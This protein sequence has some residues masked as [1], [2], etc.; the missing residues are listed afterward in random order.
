MNAIEKKSQTLTRQDSL[1]LKG[2]AI[3]FLI[4][5]HCFVNEEIFS[6]YDVDF[7]PLGQY[8][9][10]RVNS[11]FKTC[12]C[13]FTFISGY[14]LLKSYDPEKPHS[15][16][17]T[18]KWTVRRC[19]KTL[20]GLWAAWV[21]LMI[22][23][24]IINGYP[25][26]VYFGEGILKGIFYMAVEAAGGAELLGTPSMTSVWWYI[27]AAVIYII[28]LP[29]LSEAAEKFGYTCVMAVLFVIPRLLGTGFPGS[30]NPY[31]FLPM[32]LVGMCFSRYNVFEKL[33]NQRLFKNK[34]SDIIVQFLFWM[35]ALAAAVILYLRLPWKVLWEVNFVVCPL[36]FICFCKKYILNIPVLRQV[37]AFFGKYSM[38][39]YLIHSVLKNIVFTDFLYSLH[40]FWLIPTVLFA[41]SLVCS[42]GIEALKRAVHYDKWVEKVTQRI[43]A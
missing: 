3:L 30:M 25:A 35:L 22:F 29:V 9:V 34:K 20:S 15:K 38:N 24:Q 41:V 13:I 43:I 27:G 14:G 17:Y 10:L 23:C 32:F 18:V 16:E 6:K 39:I 19:L 26:K 36:I 8:F 40:Y 11:W 7:R 1:V 28:L 33:G 31:T 4:I 37:L 42:V 2:I 21:L 12:I 5:Y